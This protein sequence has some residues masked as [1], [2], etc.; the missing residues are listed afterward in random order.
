MESVATPGSPSTQPRLP[1]HPAI[2]GVGLVTPLGN[3]AAQT[4]GALLAGRFITDHTRLNAFTGPTRVA[5]LA[6]VAAAE[7]MAQANWTSQI[8]SAPD[9]ALILATSKGPVEAWLA[10]SSGNPDPAGSGLA[11]SG[12]A[13]SSL[14]E[15]GLADPTTQLARAFSI[16]PGPRLTLSA[17]CASGLH[18]LAR[19]ALALT[20]G[21]ASRALVVAVEASAHPLFIASFQRLGVL[22]PKNHGC[23]PFDR[24]R[25]GFIIS[26]A[27]AALCLEFSPDKKLVRLENYRIAADATHLTGSDPEAKSLGAILQQVVGGRPI[28]FFHAHSTATIINDPI[29]LAAIQQF[30]GANLPILYS[31]KAA[32]GHTLGAAGLISVVLNFLSHKSG[33]VPQNVQSKTPLPMNGLTFSHSPVHRP[34]HRSVAL[35]AGF[36]GALGA[37]TLISQTP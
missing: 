16:G 21:E 2:T 19:A 8:R 5:D 6:K 36:G 23:R 24:T 4:W 15:S 25:K 9:T 33:I 13:Q 22:A 30:A 12:L 11:E 3:T 35:A 20:S 10:G 18:A 34:I 17:A 37:V 28:D 7:A 32:L 1:E 14:A 29:E 27:A 26:E 31:H